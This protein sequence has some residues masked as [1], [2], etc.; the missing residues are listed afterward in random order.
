M[1]KPR[2]SDRLITIVAIVVAVVAI[3][4]AIIALVASRNNDTATEQDSALYIEYEEFDEP[5]DA[6][7]DMGRYPYTSLRKLTH[8]DVAYLSPRDLKIMRNEI[9]ARH[10]YIFQTNDM[11]Q[12]FSK[13]SWYRPTTTNV[14]LSSIEQYNVNFIKSY[15]H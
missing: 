6:D 10:G 5:T 3:I 9:F 2:T 11:K 12:Y 15:E 13:Q 4:V 1:R 7:L 8:A 14:Q